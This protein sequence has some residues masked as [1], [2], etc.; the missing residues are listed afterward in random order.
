MSSFLACRA[1]EGGALAL[2][3]GA[4]RRAADPAGLA[5]TAI[6]RRLQLEVTR[7]ALGAHKVTQAAAALLHRA[8][9][10]LDDGPVQTIGSGTGNA[11]CSD[12]GADA[13]HE[14]GFGGIDVAHAHHNVA[15]QKHLLDGRTA[16]AQG[17]MKGRCIETAIQ[18]LHPQMAEQLA[19]LWRV[20]GRH[21]NHS[22]KTARVVQAQ[23]TVVRD[24]IHVV[25]RPRCGLMRCKVQTARHAQMQKQQPIV[26]VHK[27][28]LAAPAHST[29]GLTDKD[30]G[31]GAQRPPQRLAQMQSNDARPGNAVCKALARDF[32]FRQF[33]HGTQDT[34][35]YDCRASRSGTLDYHALMKFWL[36]T[37]VWAPW[38]LAFGMQT[39][40]A[41]GKSDPPA[42]QSALDGPLFYQLLLGE[43]QVR[44]G[45]PGAGFSLIL[46]AARKTRDPA[47]F[48]R[49]VDLALQAR[50]GE[51]ALQAAQTWKRELPNAQ[52]PNRYILQILLALNRIEEA[53]HALAQS[54][55][56]LPSSE[57]QAAIVSIP[58]VFARVPDKAQAARAVESALQRS[59]DDRSLQASAW[60]TIG[61]MHR[62]AR[63]WPQAIN[64]A[65]Q[66]HASDPRAQGPL[67]LGLSLLPQ[68]APEIRRML[69]NAMQTSA[70]AELRLGY[71]RSLMALQANADALQQ[72]QRL[73]DQHPTFAPGWLVQ[74]M[75]QLELGQADQASRSLQ[76]H[77]ALSKDSSDPEQLAGL[78]EALMALSQ[79]A[80]QRKDLQQADRW[81]Q[82]IPA[83][84]DPV[85]LAIRRAE[86]LEQQ[87]RADEARVVLTQVQPASAEQARRKTLALSRWMREHRQ[88][89]QAHALLEQALAESPDDHELLTEFSLVMEKLKKYEEME[90]VLRRLMTM[91]PQDPHAYNALGYSLA[92]RNVRLEE[93]RQLILKAVELAPQDPFIQDSLGWVEFRMGRI[94][95]A[96]RILQAAYQARP[97]AEIAAHLGEVLWLQDRKQDAA[98]IWREG[99]LLK[100]DHEVLIETMQRLGF[101]P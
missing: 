50:S 65:L 21:P 89:A 44:Q 10:H 101:K 86:L 91:R 93:A 59:L 30:P 98:R 49:A 51:A 26:Q 95:E 35:V 66:G 77:V 100:A 90:T 82:Q 61:R 47:L 46:D 79:L 80:Q 15:G 23:G 83:S 67:I 85:R 2:H 42:P 57:K 48:Q 28:I 24:Q 87:G 45:S 96:T 70:S 17:R 97:D 84:A 7:L 76:Q 73:T 56:D 69:D 52:E 34:K 16:L 71:A 99:M 22:T 13:R 58:R 68:G 39:A 9:E 12:C 4:D 36:C 53:G 31:I 60:T 40:T 27:Q 3:D 8:R 25:M 14:Q 29:D 64:A 18:G 75:L 41:A 92:D 88:S 94:A 43:L 72:L 33:G 32:N 5:G 81:L 62:D 38:L 6:D 78:T 19:G 54:I 20:F 63:Q 37:A 55:Q 1:E 11:A 74:G